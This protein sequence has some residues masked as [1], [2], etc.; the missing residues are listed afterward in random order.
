MLLHN[1]QVPEKIDL[2]N[3]KT[4]FAHRSNTE[5]LKMELLFSLMN[6]PG[7]NQLAIK[8]LLWA[9]RWHLPVKFLVKP[10]IF[11]Q[12]CGGETIDECMQTS[13]NLARFHVGTILDFSVEGEKNEAGFE[14]VKEETLR[15][16][17]VAA[18]KKEIPFAV[19]KTSGIA[20]VDLMEKVQ[21]GE[22][23]SE[24]ESQELD[25]ARQRFAQI[26]R[27]AAAGNVRIFVDAEESWIQDLIDQWTYEEMALH[28][29]KTALIFNT[30]QLYRSDVLDRLKSAARLAGEEGYF[31][32]AKLVRGAYMEKESARAEREGRLN[33]IQPD[34]ASSDRDYNAA[35]EFCLD[36]ISRIHFCAGSHNEESNRLLA[37]R[38]LEKG[39]EKNDERVWFAQLLGMSDNISYTLASLGFNVAK[40][41]PYG[42]VF[43]VMPYLVR[44][45]AENTSVAGQSSREL[46]LIRSERNRRKLKK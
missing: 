10:T 1:Q 45:A 27:A 39:L 3:T 37:Q 36:N 31:I 12:F 22:E 23:I 44:R 18:G 16:I 21:R 34:K 25:R 11:S 42:P 20:S 8:S 29:R 13:A 30:Y 2:G 38:M 40:Y 46:S 5:L 26:C 32:G 4:A 9:I 35:L 41:V 24:M 33:P 6:H 19:F 17:A 14:N 15:T 7:I 43:S 28:N